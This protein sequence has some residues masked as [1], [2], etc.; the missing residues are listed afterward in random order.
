MDTLLGITVFG[1]CS[2]PYL[3]YLYWLQQILIHE[4]CSQPFSQPLC[5]TH[6][7]LQPRHES[8]LNEPG[9][10]L[11]LVSPHKEKQTISELGLRVCKKWK[12]VLV[13]KYPEILQGACSFSHKTA[14][15]QHLEQTLTKVASKNLENRE[16]P[17]E[18]LCEFD[19]VW[20]KERLFAKGC[21]FVPCHPKHFKCLD[22]N[23]QRLV[24][25][26]APVEAPQETSAFALAG[27]VGGELGEKRQGC[28]RYWESYN[29]DASEI[30]AVAIVYM[31]L[32]LPL[33]TDGFFN[34][35]FLV[36]V[37]PDSLKH[38]Q[39]WKEL[40]PMWCLHILGGPQNPPGFLD[41]FGFCWRYLRVG[42]CPQFHGNRMNE[43][44]QWNQP[45][46]GW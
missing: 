41:K 43:P 13:P 40:S 39:V 14:P 18:F 38:R 46:M 27:F 29:V 21:H 34:L 22:Q 20:P 25:L 23:C 24:F 9:Q 32:Y 7:Q 15:L 30:Q 1:C 8:D 37:L 26:N 5:Q 36:V 42:N 31:V 19:H 4:K 17:T 6:V 2:L 16:N 12:V 33:L 45:R 10:R 44:C 3:I 35:Y 11:C 28:W